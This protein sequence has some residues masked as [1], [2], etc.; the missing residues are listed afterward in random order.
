MI[1]FLVVVWFCSLFIFLYSGGIYYFSESE[2]FNSYPDIC[3]VWAFN[4]STIYHRLI[5]LFSFIPVFLPLFFFKSLLNLLQYCFCFMFCFF[6]PWGMWDLEL[7]SLALER[8]LNS[9]T[10]REVLV[11]FP[12]SFLFLPPLP[13]FI[14]KFIML[15][16]KYILPVRYK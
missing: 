6:W 8:G 3:C 15:I 11:F 12:L 2:A 4:W 5:C 14:Y 1:S 9:W 10:T 16:L 7:V 13:S